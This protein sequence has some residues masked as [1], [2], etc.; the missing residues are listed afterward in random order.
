MSSPLSRAL[1]RQAGG[2]TASL[3]MARRFRGE[4]RP[5]RRSLVLASLASLGYTLTEMAAPWPL[6][7][8]LDNVL[9]GQPWVTGLASFD[10]AIGADAR[11]LLV[12]SVL[13][14]MG[15][16]VLRGLLYYRRN[17]LTAEVGQAV[18]MRVRRRLFAH[19]QRLSLSFHHHQRTGELLTRLT[20]DILLLR[21]LVVSSLLSLVSEALVLVGLVAV[22]FLLSWRLALASLLVIPVLF[23]LVSVYASQIRQAARKQRKREGAL[24]ARTYQVLSGIHVVKLFVREADEDEQLRKLTKRSLKSGLKTTRLEARMNRDMEL[25][26]AAATALAL[27]IGAGQ[28][29]GGALSAGELVVF[30]FYMRAFHRPLRRISRVAERASKAATCVERV[31]EILDRESDLPDGDIDPPAFAGTIEID[32]RSHDYGS[33]VPV[34]GPMQLRVDPGRRLA[35]VGESGAGKS[36][37]LGFVPRLHDPSDGQVRI[38]GQDI[39]R[40]ELAGLRRQISVVPQDALLFGGTIRENI[41]YGKPDASQDEIEAASRAAQAHDFIMALPEGYDSPVG[42]RGV[43][44]SGGQRQR[45]AIARALIKDA[46]IVLLDEPA[47]GLDAVSEARVLTALD[48]LLEGR[49]AIIIAHRLETVRRADEIVVLRAGRIVARGRHA[50]LM[51]DC[52][53]YRDL[54]R[55]QNL[56][57]RARREPA[58][59]GGRP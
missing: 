18:V 56:L 41:A 42:E 45:L 16:A 8:I 58:L 12:A 53:Y 46:P 17:V 37:L 20:G 24:A 43:T 51:A 32:L 19:M 34:L 59:A 22:M 54:C 4:L 55:R 26:I 49:S 9:P 39:R 13:A 27:W 3:R 10:R 28:V 21:D 50:D 15:L 7:L 6:K 38:D 31:L 25:S 57:E 40:F 52:A 29:M 33:G 14:I 23:V 11:S 30:V 48:R 36:T 44:L 5:H 1:G 35:L 47:T 2:V